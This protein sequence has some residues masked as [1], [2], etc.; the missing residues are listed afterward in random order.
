MGLTFGHIDNIQT[1]ITILLIY[2]IIFSLG[3]YIMSACVKT[4]SH[5]IHIG[6]NVMI[7]FQIQDNSHKKLIRNLLSTTSIFVPIQ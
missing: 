5:Y 7:M 1:R 4:F 6:I 2:D 3:F